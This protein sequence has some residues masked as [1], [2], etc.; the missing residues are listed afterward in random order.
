MQKSSL[1]PRSASLLLLLLPAL[2]FHNPDPKTTP[3][4]D[5]IEGELAAYPRD[6]FRS[7]VDVDIKLTGTFGELRPDHFHSGIDIKSK[8]GRS[9]QPILAAAGGFVDR[10][11]VQ[12]GGYGNVLYIKHPNGYTTVYAHLD[13][14]AP[15]IQK[16][17]R[18]QQYRRERFEVDL[19]PKDGQFK[20]KAGEEIGKMGN[21]GGSTG[22]HLHFEIRHSATGKA[23]NPQLFGLPVPDKVA[24]EIRDMKVYFL[25]DKR[26]VAA[27]RAFPIMQKADGTYAPKT[28]DTVRIGAWR[29][30]FGVKSFDEMSGFRNDNGIYALQMKVDDQSA[31]LWRMEELDFD[32]TRY[33]NAHIDYPARQ[34]NGAWF[35]RCFVLPGNHLSN[36]ARTETGGAV[37]LYKDK[38]VKISIRATDA[39]GNAADVVFWALRDEANMETPTAPPY[40]FAL[41]FDAESRLDVEGFSMLVP[42]NTFYETNY[43]RYQTT[44]DDSRGV[45]SPVH[46][47]GDEGTPAHKYFE[48]SLLPVNLPP[49]LRDK[50]I[51]AKCNG[52]QEQNCGG[53]WRNDRLV[54]KVRQFGDYCVMTDTDAPT[55]TPIVFGKDLRQKST[56]SFRIRDNFGVGGS[57]DGLSFRGTVDGQWVLFEHDRKSA[58]LTHTFDGRIGPGQHT[59]RLVV[60]D[61]RG[62]EGV[63]EGEF[64]K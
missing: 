56:M 39:S 41:P 43:L 61:D 22:P 6:Y 11:K 30:G 23:F 59:L 2:A 48:I 32:E 49:E 18:D 26:E 21:T 29:V 53:T 35:H 7:P 27:T 46:H 44:P 57:A 28:G 62:N 36:Y 33:M 5:N 64:L 31:Y 1:V 58:R 8:N 24:P 60:K 15:D 37:A 13:R 14:F 3:P 4:S 20:V 19:Q 45:Y 10:I 34:K 42:K 63:F 25:N 52:R 38:P 40:Q 47:L 17:V 12:A 51:I 16:Y 9:G 55:I 54:T 50:A